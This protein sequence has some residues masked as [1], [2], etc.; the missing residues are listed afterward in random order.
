LEHS[1]KRCT[2][3]GGCCVFWTLRNEPTHIGWS[4]GVSAE[5]RHLK[6]GGNV[7]GGLPTRRYGQEESF[8]SPLKICAIRVYPCPSVVKF[9]SED[10]DS[11]IY[12]PQR[13]TILKI[14]KAGSG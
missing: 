6:K 9:V 11:V 13:Q 8:M 12:N 2:D 7:C 4:S 10:D 1:S 14:G 5:R 3:P